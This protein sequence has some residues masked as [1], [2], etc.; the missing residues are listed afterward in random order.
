MAQTCGGCDSG[1]K[2]EPRLCDPIGACSDT[3]L[4]LPTLLMAG[5]QL[6]WWIAALRQWY[7]GKEDRRF[8][9]ESSF[10]GCNVNDL[11]CSNDELRAA[12]RIADK[13]DSQTQ[14]R[15]PG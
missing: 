4:R 5:I 1:S 7:L 2:P 11:E 6:A 12:L 10:I 8:K 9:V 3:A 14:F 13:A 15:P